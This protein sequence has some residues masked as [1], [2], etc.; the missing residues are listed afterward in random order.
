MPVIGYIIIFNDDIERFLRISASLIGLNTAEA[1]ALTVNS[2]YYL[3]FGALLFSISNILFAAL[4]P[5][6]VKN[7]E[8][9]YDFLAKEIETM[10]TYRFEEIQQYLRDEFSYEASRLNHPLISPERITR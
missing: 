1:A 9:R 2:L 4:C 6:V 7:S 10:S 8:S 3:Y 5:N